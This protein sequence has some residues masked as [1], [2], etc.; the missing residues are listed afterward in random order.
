MTP[1]RYDKHCAECHPL[2]VQ[3][4]A[5][6]ND[7]RVHQ[8][9]K[10]F[11]QEPAPHVAPDLVLAILRERLRLLAQRNPIIGLDDR[12]SEPLRRLPGRRPAPLV[13]LELSGWVDDQASMVQRLLFDAAGG[14]RYCHIAKREGSHPSGLPEYDPTNVPASWFP[15]A[16]FSHARH[17]LMPCSACHEQARTSTRTADVLMPLKSKCAA[18]HNNQTGS[19]M[20]A[21]AD[22]LECHQYHGRVAGATEWITTT[23]Q[24]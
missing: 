13:P 10:A 9:A 22:C 12:M 5:E 1:V 16:K 6:T 18:C 17:G 24:E 21:R 2:T 23:G 7:E 4:V 11:G 15:H 20:R 8:A 19:R 14:C 3:I